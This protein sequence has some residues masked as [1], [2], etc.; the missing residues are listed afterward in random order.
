M[1]NQ[2]LTIVVVSA[3]IGLSACETTGAPISE[4]YGQAFQETVNS[5]IV[6]E[7]AVPGAPIMNTD[8]SNAAVDR[9]LNDQV[10]QPKEVSDN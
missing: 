6:D 2:K 1:S 8:L 4:R 9:Y 10:K 3:I 5:Q 7:T